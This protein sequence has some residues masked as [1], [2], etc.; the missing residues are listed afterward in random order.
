MS[1]IVK[2]DS[3]DLVAGA[4]RNLPLASRQEW[5]ESCY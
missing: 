1:A 4:D 2:A 3:S 5:V